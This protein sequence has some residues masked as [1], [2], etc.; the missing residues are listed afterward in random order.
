MKIRPKVA[1]E[2][3][4][5]VVLRRSGLLGLVRA[6]D[7]RH[8]SVLR[9]LGYHRVC[10]LADDP[11]QGD[12]NVISATPRGFADQMRLL[13]RHYKPVGLSEVHASLEGGRPLPPRAVLVTFDDGY[14]DFLTHAWPI[15]KS[16]EVPVVLFVPTAFPDS[17][18]RFWW[19]QVWQQVSRARVVRLWVQGMGIVDLRDFRTRWQ[20]VRHMV[21]EMRP[22]R[23]EV[24]AERMAM[25]GLTVGTVRNTPPPV[26]GWDELRRL[27]R[28][29]VTI[30]S[31]G[32]THASLPVLTAEE[33]V[34]EIEQSQA[35][36]QRELGSA[37]PVFAY[38]F[39]H[40]DER[41]ATVLGDRG[42]LAAI[43]TVP[44]QNVVPVRNRYSLFRQSV[45]VKHSLS[46]IQFGLSGFFHS[47]DV[48]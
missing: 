10:D 15:L 2:R 39:G 31:H 17:G 44:G 22:L 32:R 16:C 33:I 42:F 34:L 26:L 40:Y 30:G 27:S 3:V 24:I 6:L 25:L 5:D 45:N 36:L 13:A 38:P 8:D 11:L 46:R 4:A 23:T 29:G 21:R 37:V 48:S 18:R 35:D 9:I 28:E 14:R 19:D 12:P 41:A 7:S 43:G 1:V 47:A 20:V